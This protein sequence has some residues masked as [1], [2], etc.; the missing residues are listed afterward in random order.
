MRPKSI[1]VIVLGVG[2]LGVAAWQAQA[3]DTMAAM[4]AA[5]AGTFLLIRGL[6]NTVR[7]GL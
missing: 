3:G 5:G 2:L 7:A 1:L 6:S 4:I